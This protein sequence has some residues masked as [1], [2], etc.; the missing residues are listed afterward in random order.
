MGASRCFSPVRGN[1]MRVTQLDGCGRPVYGDESVGVSDGFVSV[2]F[3]ANTDDGGWHGLQALSTLSE[4]DATSAR[5]VWAWP[6][7]AIN[8]LPNHTFLMLTRATVAG[9]S[10]P[11]APERG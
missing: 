2:A 10:G 7:V 8:A 5:F 9:W 11:A 1:A 4:E 6:N 3:T